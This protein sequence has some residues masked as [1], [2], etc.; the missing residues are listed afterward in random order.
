DG[1]MKKKVKL[2]FEKVEGLAKIYQYYMIHAKEEISY[3]NRELTLEDVLII[4][5]E[6]GE[7]DADD[8]DSKEDFIEDNEV[9]FE[10]LNEILCLEEKFD[11]DHEIFEGNG[12]SNNDNLR[13]SSENVE[14]NYDYNVDN[15]VDEIFTR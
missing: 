9:E 15:L 10:L 4:T 1:S 5:N 3:I 12:R 11:L 14:P 13:S 2:V 7:L 8:S 6:S